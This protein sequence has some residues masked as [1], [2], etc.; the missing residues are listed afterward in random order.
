[1][2]TGGLWIT[3]KRKPPQLRRDKSANSSGL[4]LRRFH[5][6]GFGFGGLQVGFRLLPFGPAN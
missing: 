5:P 3:A 2:R 4:L 6:V 1:M